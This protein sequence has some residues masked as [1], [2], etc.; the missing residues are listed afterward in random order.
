MFYSTTDGQY[1]NQGQAFTINEVQYPANWLNLSSPEEKTE[2]GLQEVI[3]TNSPFNPVYYWTGETLVGAELTYT[4]IPKDLAEVQKQSIANVDRAS[5]AIL[6]PSD[7]MASK[8]YETKTEI[9][10]DWAAWRQSV[11]EEA[12]SVTASINAATT[13]EEVIAA[14]SAISWPAD[15]NSPKTA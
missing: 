1:I 11:R 8:A 4:G 9:P 5:Y 7:Y 2:L 6:L 10:S 15:P 12:K 13:V 3:A 14:V